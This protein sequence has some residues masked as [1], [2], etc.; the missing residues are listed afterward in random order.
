MKKNEND[1]IEKK[2]SRFDSIISNYIRIT[3]ILKTFSIS[4][5]ENRFSIFPQIQMFRFIKTIV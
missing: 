3:N 1:E 5:F 2:Y 4:K